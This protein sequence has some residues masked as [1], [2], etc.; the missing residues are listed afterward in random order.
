M[1]NIFV[2]LFVLFVLSCKKDSKFKDEQLGIVNVSVSTTERFT[3]TA[4]N[5]TIPINIVLSAAAP[6]IFTVSIGVN[7]DTIN[8]LINNQQLAGAIL[9]DNSYYQL[10]KTAEIRFGLDTFAIPL[11]VSMQAIEKYYGNK[12]ALAVTLSNPGKNNTLNAAAKTAIVI[13]NTT[14]IIRQSEIHYVSFTEAGKILEQPSGTDHILGTKEVILPVS[15]SL[16]GVAGSAFTLSVSAAPDTAQSL[17]DDG[18]LG[19]SVLLKEGDDYTLPASIS[20]P[21]NTNVAKFN[22]IVKTDALRMYELNKPALAITLGEPT[23][24]LLDSV[25]R[26]LVM[27]LDPSRLIETDI[28]NTNI[29]YTVQYDNGNTNE[30]SPKLIDNNVNTKFLL[31]SFTSAWMQLE[32]ATPQITGA[33]TITSANDAPGRDPKNWKIEGSNDGVDWT[34]LD[35]RTNQTFGSRFLTVKYTFS[36]QDAYKFYRYTVTAVGSGNLWQQAEWRLLKRP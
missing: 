35:Q 20:F 2:L 34:I 28:T 12:L 18:T 27:V 1:R 19:G 4:D 5:V 7:N 14:D 6:K 36:N 16:G 23:K 25:K 24:H 17:I 31:G 3:K 32:F 8:E 10:P 22:V 29:K 33:Y 26:T 21:A 30:N 13:I 11:Q 15:V 9:L